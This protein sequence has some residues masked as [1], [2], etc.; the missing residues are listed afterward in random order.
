MD[1]LEDYTIKVNLQPAYDP[2]VPGSPTGVDQVK[3][4]ALT[5][6]YQFAVQVNASTNYATNQILKFSF[7]FEYSPMP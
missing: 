5:N 3:I 6:S 1:I 2:L 4:G 7:H